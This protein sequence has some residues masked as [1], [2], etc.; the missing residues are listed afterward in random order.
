MRLLIFFYSL[1]I[2]AN[3]S[4][5]ARF[6]IEFTFTNDV[7]IREGNKDFNKIDSQANNSKTVQEIRRA[8]PG[9]EIAR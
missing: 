9:F 1:S 6:G 4:N 7:L 2:F 3:D 5:E 8:K